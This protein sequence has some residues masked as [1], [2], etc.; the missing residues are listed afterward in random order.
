MRSIDNKFYH[1]KAWS[2]CRNAYIQSHSLC[3]RCLQKGLIAPSEIVHHK[4]H[5]D[6]SNVNDPAVALSF[7]NLEA[8]CFSCHNQEHFGDKTERRWSFDENGK[9]ISKEIES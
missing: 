1:S 3:E 4:I 2:Q 7:S 6:E 9:L 5:L 8:L